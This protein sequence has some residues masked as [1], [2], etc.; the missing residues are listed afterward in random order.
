M[1]KTQCTKGP[2]IKDK[3]RIAHSELVERDLMTKLSDLPDHLQVF[4]RT[5]DFNTITGGELCTKR[6]L[7]V[8]LLG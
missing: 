6:I 5:V 2:E 8:L 4:I 1:Y 7:R 3:V